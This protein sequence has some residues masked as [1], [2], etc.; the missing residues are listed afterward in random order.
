MPEAPTAEAPVVEAPAESAPVTEQEQP[1]A[2]PAEEASPAEGEAA[3]KADEGTHLDLKE[4]LKGATAAELKT[5]LESVPDEV[6]TE[7]EAEIER[8]A[9]QKVRTQAQEKA[10]ATD[11]RTSLWQQSAEVGKQAE[12]YLR[13][14]VR[15]FNAGDP[16]ALADASVPAA[17]DAYRNGAI[18][19]VAF[20]NEKALAPL[21]EKY[22]PEPTEAELKALEKPLYDDAKRGTFSQLPVVMELAVARARAEGKAEGLKEGQ[23]KLEASESLAEKI[24]AIKQVAVNTPVSVNGA[25]AAPRTGPLTVEEASTLPIEELIRRSKA[26]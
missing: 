14:A 2:A 4:L 22:L 15:R 6:R 20:D 9:E 5:V 17:I 24:K 13:D 8:R 12:D 23:K 18:A 10:Q 7:V 21:R 19:A 3:P 11:A 16:E 26:Q 1:I 25:G